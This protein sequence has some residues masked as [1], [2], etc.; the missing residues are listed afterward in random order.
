MIDATRSQPAPRIEASDRPQTPKEAADAFEKQ[1]VEQLVSKLTSKMFEGG[2]LGDD[3]PS[4][5]GQQRSTQRDMLTEMLADRLV[6]SGSI[7]I[8]GQ[9]EQRWK[10]MQRATPP[11]SQDASDV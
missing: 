1:F 2:L 8:S 6:E 3:G 11:P 5:M 10:T 7:D 4:W 9:L